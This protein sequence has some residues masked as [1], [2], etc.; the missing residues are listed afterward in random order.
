M[1]VPYQRKSD[2]FLLLRIYHICLFHRP[3]SNIAWFSALH[4][5][6]SLKTDNMLFMKC[7]NDSVHESI[8]RSLALRE[9]E[10]RSID[11]PKH[12]SLAGMS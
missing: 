6:T 9:P 4:P 12:S 11:G 1:S 3:T 7:I 10:F 5:S 2:H 8:Q